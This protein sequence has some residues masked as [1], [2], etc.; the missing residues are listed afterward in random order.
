MG[1]HVKS[2]NTHA[3]IRLRSPLFQFIQTASC[4]GIPSERGRVV[5]KKAGHAKIAELNSIINICTRGLYSF[6]SFAHCRESAC[7]QR[8][9]SRHPSN[10]S[11]VVPV[12]ALYLHPSSTPFLPY[13]THASIVSTCPNHLN[14]SDPLNS[15]PHFLYQL[16][17]TP[18]HS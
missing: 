5:R 17:Y 3:I 12:P 4:N 9:S 2:H 6:L 7:S 14:T 1:S 16:L 10:L 15:P 18:R 11:S 8:P 13:G